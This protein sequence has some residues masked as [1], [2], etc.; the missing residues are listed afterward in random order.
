LAF[1]QLA[2]YR[3]EKKFLSGH[4]KGGVFTFNMLRSGRGLL[5]TPLPQKQSSFELGFFAG[6][7]WRRL[8]GLFR[9]VGRARNACPRCT[10][11]RPEL[12]PHSVAGP[13]R[14]GEC[15][16]RRRL[17]FEVILPFF[18]KRRRRLQ[19]RV[20]GTA[21]CR[22]FRTFLTEFIRTR[23]GGG[24]AWAYIGPGLATRLNPYERV[25]AGVDGSA[26]NSPFLPP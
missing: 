12:R 26:V 5:K 15:R 14:M 10:P 24:G 6:G 21:W 22:I 23:I 9:E 13:G 2:H 20:W 8:W 25:S 18:E 17:R 3:T 19:H 7:E 4:R 1:V 16:L 11:Q